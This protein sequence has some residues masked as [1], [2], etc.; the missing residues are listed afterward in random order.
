MHKLSNTL[1][2]L[3]H[4]WLGGLVKMFWIP[5]I[6]EEWS[7]WKK[8]TWRRGPHYH[9]RGSHSSFSSVW[10]H[11]S[12]EGRLA[13]RTP[14]HNIQAEWLSLTIYSCHLLLE[15]IYHTTRGA[16]RR[17]IPRGGEK[18]PLAVI[19]YVSDMSEQI[20]KPC[21]KLQIRHD[22]TKVKYPL[23]K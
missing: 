21:E 15:E 19:P 2:Q 23:P 3:F 14:H 18:Q 8:R 16:G 7:S 9:W 1:H 10:S 11:H 5:S 17:K 4:P 13:E 6:S 22:F 12:T 20:R